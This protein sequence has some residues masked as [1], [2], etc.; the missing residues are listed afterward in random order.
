MTAT[1]VDDSLVEG[2]HTS[3]ISYAAS[4]SDTNY[5]AIAITPVTAKVIDNDVAGVTISQS[6]NSTDITEGGATDS[7]TVVLNTQPTSDVT[8]AIN[9]DTMSQLPSILTVKVPVVQIV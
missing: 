5:N 2:N 8:I 3:T 1:A 6:G 4:S 9:P 7:Y